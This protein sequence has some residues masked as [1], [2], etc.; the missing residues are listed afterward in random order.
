M[1]QLPSKTGPQPTSPC[2]ASD[3]PFFNMA[4]SAPAVPE[5]CSGGDPSTNIN[6]KENNSTTAKRPRGRP[7][8]HGLSG[9]PTYKSFNEAKQRCTNPKHPDYVRYGGRGIEFRFQSVTELV[10]EIGER[11][12]GTSLDRPNNNLH[13]QAGNVRW[14][15]PKEQANNRRPAFRHAGNWFAG[16]EARERYL[17]TARH[18]ALSIAFLNDYESLS[19]EDA[20]FLDERHAATSLPAATFL[21]PGSDKK[22][23][24]ISLPSLNHPGAS[25]VLRVGPRVRFRNDPLSKRGLLSGTQDIPLALNC[26]EE[27][28]KII[29]DFVQNVRTAETGL[30]YSGC[31][32]SFSA[33]RIEGR[34]LA[35][36]GRLTGCRRQARVMLSAEVASLLCA[37]QSEPLL[38]PEFLFLPDL[39]VWP[40]VFGSDRLLRYRLRQV[41]VD[42]I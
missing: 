17:Q 4:Q 1:K 12:P 29:N 7:P 14:A 34:L 13:Y 41:L 21:T 31:D 40:S 33:N 6:A 22:Q 3:K 2:A 25:T 32:A 16:K 11:P 27:E 28:L 8:K 5:L 39:N 36:A 15:Y 10:A 18:W 19:P 42:R 35:T 9:T 24:Y 37:D 38:Q 20:S 30:I 23:N 26:C